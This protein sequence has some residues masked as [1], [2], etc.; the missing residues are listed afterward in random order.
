M[1]RFYFCSA[2]LLLLFSCSQGINEEAPATPLVIN[3]GFESMTDLAGNGK[4]SVA[5]SQIRWTS[6][7][8]D[9]VLYVFDSKGVKNVFT[10]N[11]I[12]HHVDVAQSPV[13]DNRWD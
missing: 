11:S 2:L 13:N 7:A 3:T 5:G 8:Q 10:R 12:G 9:K 6:A 4:T 1:K